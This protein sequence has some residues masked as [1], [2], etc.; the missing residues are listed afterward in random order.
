MSKNKQLFKDLF[1]QSSQ[2]LQDVKTSLNTKTKN[3]FVARLNNVDHLSSLKKLNRE[4]ASIKSIKDDT[5]YNTKNNISQKTLK[6]LKKV[7]PPVVKNYFITANAKMKTEYVTNQSKRGNK[8]YYDN[9]PVSKAITATSREN[10]IEKFKAIIMA[11]S[12]KNGT[13]ADTSEFKHESVDDFDEIAIN[14]FDEIDASSEMDMFLKCAKPMIYDFIP[15]KETYNKNEGFC[16]PDVMITVYQKYIPTLNLKRFTDLCYQVRGEKPQQPNMLSLLDSG[17]DQD[18]EDI[19]NKKWELKDGVTSKMLCDICKILDISHYSFDITNKCFLKHISLY[20]HYPALV[21]YCANNHMY[22]IDNQVKA[23]SLIRT[24]QA[25]EHKIKSHCI[26]EEYEATKN[27]YEK[28]PIFDDINVNE[29]NDL[30]YKSSIIIYQKTNLNDELDE[31]IAKF[32]YIPKVKN[33]KYIITEIYYNNDDQDIVLT[34]DPNDNKLMTYKD[35]KILCEKVKIEFKNQSFGGLIKQLKEQFL[36]SDSIRHIFTKDERT[37]LYNDLN[38]K[39]N[40]CDKELTL[41]GFHIDHILP[42]SRGGNNENENLQLLCKPCH[43]EKTRQE[44][45]DKYVKESKTESS[46]NFT[47][48]EIMNSSLNSKFAFVEKLNLNQI[49]DVKLNKYYVDINKCRKNILYYSKYDYPLFTVMDEPI[50]YKGVKKTGLYFVETECY[51]PLRG[52]GWYSQAMIEYCLQKHLIEE[53]NIKYAV[54]SSLTVEYNYYNKFI[55]YLYDVLG[56]KA[57]LS[58]NTIIGMFK[59]KIRENWK[60]LLISE[61]VNTA[62]YHYLNKNGSFIDTKTINDKNYYQVFNRYTT[63]NQ[64]SEAPLYNQ[65]LDIEA[66]E[67]HKLIN[68]IQ[69]QNGLCLSVRTDCI[70]CVFPRT[71][72]CPF[73]CSDNKNIDG[74][75][76]D[77]DKKVPKYKLEDKDQTVD[78][79]NIIEKLPNYKRS[80]IYIL[81]NNEYEIIPDVTDNDFKPL[82]DTILNSKKSIHIDGRAGCGKSTLIKLLHKELDDKKIKYISLAPTNKASRI[83]DGQTIHMFVAA[84]T[85]KTLKELSIKYIFIDEV[86]MMTECFYKY[87]LILKA[88][89][90]DIKFILSGDYSQLLPVAERLENCNYKD[91]LALFELVDGSRLQL[92]KC[93]RSDDELFNML[94]PENINNLKKESFGHLQTSINICFTNKKRIQINDYWMKQVV[95]KSKKNSSDILTFK[96]LEYDNNSQDV[97]L[98]A[99][100]PLIARKNS[101]GLNICNNDTFKIQQIN[102]KSKT[103]IITDVDK[104]QTINFD[105]FQK[106]FYVAYCITTHKSQGMTINEAYTIHEFEKFD[107]RLKYVSLSRST[108]KKNINTV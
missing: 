66:I 105:D 30:K 6:T 86:S 99:G 22:Y 78:I 16:V 25:Q 103:I 92:T 74:Y 12:L 1:A 85:G 100:M 80:E 4:L 107:E 83:I 69:S 70:E 42:L 97:S 47:T 45:D 43:F 2:L 35:I 87:F 14:S 77:D 20:R 108:N 8:I 50:I 48:K 11:E 37:Q 10:A 38:K 88:Y 36:S 59:P 52:N 98:L 64:E 96:K 76:F 13:G 102:N 27:M 89:R 94:K 32:N 7:K 44:Q 93:R 73:T 26:D 63:E 71:N 46:F 31:I 9:K 40:M 58:V 53:A 56:D 90:P 23:L 51:L 17:I 29:L 104:K 79:D 62:Y 49:C 57:K 82:V 19:K 61:D 106:M 5:M 68:L 81:K 41:K 54:Y 72:E 91:S 95:R 33:Q 21:Y 67:V 60:S 24:A 101:K 39:C 18:E 28:K 84:N 15:S 65:I 75:Y 3:N 34:I 55:D